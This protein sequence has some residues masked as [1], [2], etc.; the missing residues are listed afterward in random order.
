MGLGFGSSAA[1]GASPTSPAG[2]PTDLFDAME[3]GDIDARF[4]AKDSK[5]GR[6][7]LQNKTKQPVNVAI[8]EAFI[9]VPMAQFGGGMGGGGFGGG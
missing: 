3:S 2:E 5:R 6:I 1:R 7:I 9:G 4:I 8:P